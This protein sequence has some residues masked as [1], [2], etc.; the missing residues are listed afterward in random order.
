MSGLEDFFFKLLRR[1]LIF[2][3]MVQDV[4]IQGKEP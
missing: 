4:E 2:S 3:F 1:D